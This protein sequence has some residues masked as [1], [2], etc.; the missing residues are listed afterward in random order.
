MQTLENADDNTR[1]DRVVINNNEHDPTNIDL[2]SG[3]SMTDKIT[4]IWLKIEER[5]CH[6]CSLV[7]FLILL[8]PNFLKDSPEHKTYVHEEAVARLIEKLFL[9]TSLIGIEIS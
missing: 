9:G 7:G 1:I 2:W 3:N 4:I 8:N 6:K 5:L